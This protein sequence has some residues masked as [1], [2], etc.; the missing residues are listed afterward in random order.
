MYVIIA[1]L[2]AQ[3][4]GVKRILWHKAISQVR[5]PISLVT[6]VSS[7]LASSYPTRHLSEGIGLS[8]RL[9]DFKLEFQDS[10]GRRQEWLFTGPIYIDEPL[11]N[12]RNWCGFG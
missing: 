9:R 10:S 12:S 3:H 5:D 2:I 11:I 6:I 4:L 1:D 7:S 8:G